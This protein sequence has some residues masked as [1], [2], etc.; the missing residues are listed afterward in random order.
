[1]DPNLFP[2]IYKIPQKNIATQ[3]E[4]AT[5]CA[6]TEIPIGIVAA[7]I[8][9]AVVGIDDL[10]AAGIR[11]GNINIGNSRLSASHIQVPGTAAAGAFES[12]FGAAGLAVPIDVF[13]GISFSRCIRNSIGSRSNRISALGCGR[14]AENHRS[15]G[16]VGD[17]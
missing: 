17:S 16:A 2:K 9:G 1:M 13:E 3:P 5:A 8:I 4:K 11:I 14:I 12:D 15:A 6:G 7:V 10:S